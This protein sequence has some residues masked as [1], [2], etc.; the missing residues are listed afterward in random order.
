MYNYRW[1]I[2][3]I[4]GYPE[5]EGLQNVI[6]TVS[7]ELEIRDTEDHSIHYIRESTELGNPNPENFIDYLEL[8]QEDILGFVWNSVGKE[9]TEQRAKQE[10]DDLRSPATDKLIS[11]GMPWMAGCCPDGEGMDQVGVIIQNQQ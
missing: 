10:L 3:R 11:F 8:S 6:G 9:T 2:D 4:D 5:K 1:S 7:W